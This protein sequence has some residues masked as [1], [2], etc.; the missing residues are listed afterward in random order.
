MLKKFIAIDI[1][2]TMPVEYYH[3]FHSV[4]EKEFIGHY[5]KNTKSQ[6]YFIDTM[7]WKPLEWKEK[8]RTN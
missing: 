5:L 6:L 3:T 2:D 4:R 1:N 8:V 7:E